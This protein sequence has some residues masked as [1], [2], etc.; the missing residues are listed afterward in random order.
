[1]ERRTD[2]MTTSDLD[3]LT[4]EQLVEALEGITTKMAEGDIGIEEVAEL[5]ERAGQLQEHAAARLER[6]R[7]RIEGLA[8]ERTDGRTDGRTES[9]A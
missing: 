1:V 7:E 5:Y 8:D 4:Y 6:V 9:P 3:A 2:E